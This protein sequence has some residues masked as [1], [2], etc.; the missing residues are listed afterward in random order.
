MEI[1]E[2][3]LKVDDLQ[4]TIDNLIKFCKTS[5]IGSEQL[6]EVVFED[7]LKQPVPAGVDLREVEL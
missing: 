2:L 7:I 6:W 4:C 1:E 5:A 3:E